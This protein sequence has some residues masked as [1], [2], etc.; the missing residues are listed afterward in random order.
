MWQRVAASMGR[1]VWN[2]MVAHGREHG[3]FDGFHLEPDYGEGLGRLLTGINAALRS[4]VVSATM[5]HN[6]VFNEGLRFHFSH[7]RVPLLLSQTESL[8]DNVNIDLVLRRTH[9]SQTEEVRWA[10]CSG[11]DYIYRPRELKHLCFYQFVMWYERKKWTRSELKEIRK[12]KSAFLRDLPERFLFQ[13]SHP[14]FS[15]IYLVKRDKFVVPK[16]YAT[17]G[18][19]RNIEDLEFMNMHE[20]A[21]D[22]IVDKMREDYGKSALMLFYPFR[23]ADV[24]K[25][26][27]G[28]CWEK[29]VEQLGIERERDSTEDEED[30]VVLPKTREE[31]RGV[32]GDPSMWRR[33]FEILQNIQDRLTTEKNAVRARDLV[34]RATE[35]KPDTGDRKKLGIDEKEDNFD[36]DIDDFENDDLSG[37]NDASFQA[38]MGFNS[39]CFHSSCSSHILALLLHIVGYAVEHTKESR[40]THRQGRYQR[41]Q[42]RHPYRRGRQRRLHRDGRRTENRE[43]QC[44]R[45]LPSK[46]GRPSRVAAGKGHIRDHT[47]LCGG[48]GVGYHGNH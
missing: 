39:H 24:L 10:D 31:G 32:A 5:A 25:S 9:V 2:Q 1:R 36:V 28:S 4:D 21:S 22:S 13:E 18:K 34:Q 27:S 44:G 20:S 26:D 46:N 23:S 35:A 42:V 6:L 16:I 48:V 7:D 29:F 38:S 45:S 40:H 19:L 33:G 47:V 8:L 15:Y 41:G 11:H 43:S 30:D 12:D 37:I 17:S 14:G 3:S